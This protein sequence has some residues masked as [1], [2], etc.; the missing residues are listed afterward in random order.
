MNEAEGRSVAADGA[1]SG[2]RAR[3]IYVRYVVG[4]GLG[5]VH[6]L[7]PDISE[8]D[9]DE[10]PEL[11]D[12]TTWAWII[13]GVGALA[14]LLVLIDGVLRAYDYRKKSDDAGASHFRFQVRSFWMLL[15]YC[16]VIG[17][18]LNSLADFLLGPE[19][20]DVV[21]IFVS[22]VVVPWFLIRCIKGL[23]CLARQEPYPNPGTWLW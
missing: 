10:L 14:A 12:W 8:T 18:I 16:L 2:R 19:A 15:L 5:N 3:S 23:R 6:W 13:A 4:T 9:F 7:F 20:R 11:G 1:E 17:G 21:D 22:V